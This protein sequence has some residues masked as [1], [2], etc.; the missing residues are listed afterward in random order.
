MLYRGK[1]LEYTADQVTAVRQG[2]GESQPEFALRF[3]RSRYTII[4]WERRGVVFE[5]QSRRFEVWNG[6]VCEAI[7]RIILRS[8]EGTDDE[9]IK[10]LRDMRTFQ[11]QQRR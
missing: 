10:K 3:S 11:P 4:R 8:K 2:I 5:Y 7:H 6:A 1:R 9:R